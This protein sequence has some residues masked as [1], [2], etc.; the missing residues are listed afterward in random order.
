MSY[1]PLNFHLDANPTEITSATEPLSRIF[2]KASDLLVSYPGN[3]LLV[4]VCRLS[5]AINKYHIS[6]PTGKV[7]I[8][9]YFCQ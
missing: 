2:N 8:L 5:A 6:T 3:E 1:K 9:E 4:Q 7:N